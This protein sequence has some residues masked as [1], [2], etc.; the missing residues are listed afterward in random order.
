METYMNIMAYQK[1]DFTV[2]DIYAL[3]EGVR[4]E[5]IDGQMFYMMSPNRMH[6]KIIGELFATIRD[7][8]KMN[9][10]I[11][12]PYISP[13]AVMLFADNKNYVEPDVVVICDP[14]KLNDQGCVGAPDWI[15]EVVSPSSRRMDC[16]IKLLKYRAAGVREYWII[17]PEKQRIMVYDFENDREEEHSFEQEVTSVIMKGFSVKL[18]EWKLK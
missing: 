15:I 18:S 16:V 5:L 4:A 1:R 7:Y 17:D 9:K 2:E 11:C 14:N 10:G 3:P 12:E 6:Q 13:F 8:I